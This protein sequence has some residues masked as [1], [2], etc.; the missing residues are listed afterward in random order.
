M[1]MMIYNIFICS[2]QKHMI[3]GNIL[4]IGG[5]AS[6]T[7]FLQTFLMI[8]FGIPGNSNDILTLNFCILYA[9]YYIYI[10]KLCNFN[11]I[12]FLNVLTYLKQKNQY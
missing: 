12:D 1:K 9:K 3:S 6:L 5:K 2:V 7:F 4:V 11:I 8:L 10:H